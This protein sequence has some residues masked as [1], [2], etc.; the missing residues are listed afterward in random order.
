MLRVFGLDQHLTRFVP[1]PARPATWMMVWATRSG[2]RKI[3][4]EEAPDRVEDDD[5]RDSSG[6]RGLW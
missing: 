4:A 2:A 3:G 5:Q 6:N 1:R